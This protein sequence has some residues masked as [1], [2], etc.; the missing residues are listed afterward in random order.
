MPETDLIEDLIQAVREGEPERAAELAQQALDRGLDPLACID[1]GLTVGI[2]H[3]GEAF[4]RGELFLPD[5]IMSAEAMKS[6]MAL[7]EPALVGSQERRVLGR[8]VLGTVQGDIHEIGKTLVGTMLTA[9]GFEV[10]DIGVDQPAEAFVAA[11]EETQAD[12]V[13]MSAL[14][15]TTMV[16]Q[17]KIIEILQANG[18]REGVKVM[19][20][21]APTTKGWAQ[22]IGAD[23]HG[24]DA[25]EAVNL[26][27][28]L[29]GAE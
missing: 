20:G 22:E 18:M 17:Q 6:A 2:R 10:H 9:N 21:G 3:V 28:R 4:G 15:T 16:Q 19:I 1:N 13:G 12:M 7:L 26:A 24:E 11:V 5:L 25:L 27:K 29:M 8:V 23:G 14:L